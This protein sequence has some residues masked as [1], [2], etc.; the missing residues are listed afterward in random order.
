MGNAERIKEWLRGGNP[1]RWV[2][3]LGIGG[4][5]LIGASVVFDRKKPTVETASVSDTASYAA[6]LEKRGIRATVRRKLGSDINA[7]CGQLRRNSMKS[8]A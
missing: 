7:S 8:K 3:I 2:A 6:T 1:M 5:L 4:I